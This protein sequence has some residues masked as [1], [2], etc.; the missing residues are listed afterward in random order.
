MHTI[1]SEPCCYFST[2]S[3]PNIIS[4]IP[5]SDIVYGHFFRYRCASIKR[6]QTRNSI[7]WTAIA[8]LLLKMNSPVYCYVTPDGVSFLHNFVH[9]S[10]LFLTLTVLHWWVFYRFD[11]MLQEEKKGFRR[12]WNG[13]TSWNVVLGARQLVPNLQY[14]NN[15]LYK[16]KRRWENEMAKMLQ[17][18]NKGG[19]YWYTLMCILEWDWH[20]TEDNN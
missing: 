14:L 3:L 16:V 2:Y 18:L 19:I 7:Y 9:I 5:K 8:N 20:V 10:F 12:E 15:V 13:K 6:P 1:T 4:M 11:S 17:G